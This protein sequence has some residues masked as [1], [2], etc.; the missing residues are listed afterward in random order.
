MF[1][2]S[3]PPG[4]HFFHP[5]THMSFFPLTGFHLRPLRATAIELT[6]SGMDVAAAR[7]VKPEI[8]VG[9]SRI[10]L[11]KTKCFKSRWWA[12]FLPC[13]MAH[14]L[15]CK[16]KNA[17]R[18]GTTPTLPYLTRSYNDLKRFL[19]AN[20]QSEGQTP[21]TE[22]TWA[23]GQLPPQITI[24]PQLSALF[25]AL[26]AISVH[27]TRRNAKPPIQSKENPK[28]T[29]YNLDPFEGQGLSCCR[30]ITCKQLM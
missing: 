5:L 22:A 6:A 23:K 13:C 26:G 27:Q 19:P 30:G 7:K 25:A 12:Y 2:M 15:K 21:I 4:M 17:I 18:I 29:I 28:D 8:I 14:K 20:L 16:C 10:L 3:V 1:T 24:L 11:C 9:I